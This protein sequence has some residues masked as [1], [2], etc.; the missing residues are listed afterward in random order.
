[1][2][3]VGDHVAEGDGLLVE[4]V[5][6]IR[7]GQFLQFRR[8]HERG[9]DER[10]GVVEKEGLVFF[11]VDEVQCKVVEVIRAEVTFAAVDDFAVVIYLRF[12]VAAG[13]LPV[14][15]P[16]P[17]AIF[18]E[19]VLDGLVG[20]FVELAEL[21]FS[22]YGGGIAGGA[23]IMPK[24]GDACG[25]PDAFA[26]ADE[27][28]ET[29]ARRVKA[30]HDHYPR[31]RAQGRGVGVF[32]PQAFRGHTVEVRRG[33]DGASVAREPLGPD[34]VR[35]DEDHVGAVGSLRLRGGQAN[36]QRSQNGDQSKAHGGRISSVQ[37]AGSR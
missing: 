35:H 27:G 13:F 11:A 3:H 7:S 24:G 19:A 8:M 2:V 12:V 26:L 5:G 23:E 32:E 34:I 18:V 30:A 21:P 20:E 29:G 17:H 31:G 4:V 6:K 37:A 10:H 1:M 22:G 36:P 25:H 16:G 15:H 9:M 33:V 14:V 28:T